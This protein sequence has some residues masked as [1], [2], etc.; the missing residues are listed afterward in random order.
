MTKNS[1]TQNT[2]NIKIAAITN[3]VHGVLASI[4]MLLYQYNIAGVGDFIINATEKGNSTVVNA[5]M[6]FQLI[7]VVTG[8]ITVIFSI[9]GRQTDKMI[10]YMASIAIA[11]LNSTILLFMGFVTVFAPINILTGIMILVKKKKKTEDDDF[12]FG[13]ESEKLS[14]EKDMSSLI[15]DDNQNK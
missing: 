14:N 5:F 7:I 11:G 1:I 3:I 6:I 9:I 13:G 4:F 12:E 2:R 8:I 10:W 15:T